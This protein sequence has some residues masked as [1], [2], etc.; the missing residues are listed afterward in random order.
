MNEL[1]MHSHLQLNIEWESQMGKQILLNFSLGEA[2]PNQTIP[3]ITFH[4]SPHV[5]SWI[6]NSRLGGND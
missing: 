3:C 5:K 4:E 2:L 1:P 6:K